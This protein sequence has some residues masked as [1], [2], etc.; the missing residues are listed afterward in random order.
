[1]PQLDIYIIFNM[2]YGIIFL[3]VITYRLNI[4]NML[5]IINLLLRLR[6]LKLSLDKKYIFKVLKEYELKGTLYLYIIVL[7]SKKSVFNIFIKNILL[8]DA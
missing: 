7:F 8:Q 2:L 5:I 6:N 1:M 3:F 4:S